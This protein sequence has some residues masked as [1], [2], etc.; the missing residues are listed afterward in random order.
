MKDH[1]PKPLPVSA[2]LPKP[3]V[4]LA[5]KSPGGKSR[6]SV[7]VVKGRSVGKGNVELHDVKTGT[8]K[9][10]DSVCEDE[11]LCDKK[12]GELVCLC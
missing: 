7:G 1:F 4:S 5:L 3:S 2:C 6:D 9:E 12:I 11:G 8:G 10:V